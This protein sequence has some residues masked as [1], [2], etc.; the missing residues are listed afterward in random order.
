MP[1]LIDFTSSG[2]YCPVADVYIDPWKPVDYAII[3]HAHADH[4]RMGNLKYL[5]HKDS[6]PVLKHRLGMYTN[7]QAVDYGETIYKN[8]VKISLHPAGHIIGSSQVRLEYKGE[9]WVVSGDYKLERDYISQPFESVKC[10]VFITESTFGLPIFNWRN[11]KEVFQEINNWWAE[12]IE[13]GRYSILAGHALGKT[14]RILHN[15]DTRHGKIFAHG[16]IESMN[17]VLRRQGLPLPPI[18]KLTPE[19]DLHELHTGLILAPLSS[20]NSRWI[21]NFTPSSIAVASGWMGLRGAK[22]RKVIDRGFVLSDHADWNQLKQAV[23]LSG[24][25]KVYVTSGYSS[26]FSRWMDEKGIENYA[27]KTMF[28]GEMNEIAESVSA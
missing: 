20:L 16:S 14:Q 12:N 6:L 5:A 13:H 8:G 10:D 7:V 28:T 23:I 11:P 2:L 18:E 24:A 3:S 22:R 17:E 21:T 19:V 4:A 27:V 15:L 1:Q 25:K 9:V 26:A